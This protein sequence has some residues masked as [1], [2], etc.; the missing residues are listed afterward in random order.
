VS[1]DS[2][3]QEPPAEPP[4]P[5]GFDAG[6]A[7]SAA[8]E[9]IRKVRRTA[10]PD[11]PAEI[12]PFSF[13]SVGL[14][15]HLSRALALAPGQV[16]V[17]LACGRGGPGLWL[18]RASGASLIG[19]DFSPVAVDQAGARADLFGLRDRARFVVGD[20]TATG[21]PDAIA[22]AAVCVDSMHF[23]TEPTV[24]AAE[25]ARILRPGGRLVLT[26]WQPRLP[27]D[28]RL[29]ARLR[30]R[31]WRSILADAGFTEIRVEARPDWHEVYTRIYRIALDAGDPAGDTA[32]ADL[33][34][35]ARERLPTADLIDRVV[36]TGSRPA[37]D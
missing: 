25:A 3:Q 24:A 29:P 7:A 37:A 21:L 32:L 28:S 10:E 13:V 14:L 17:D 27:Q 16:L 18:A 31:P 2:D 15:D 35:E 4:T 26:N 19:V 33:Q 34:D 20:L 30:H 23:P 1:E 9:G 6:F 12:E 36:A 22:D 5:S 11:L 8:S